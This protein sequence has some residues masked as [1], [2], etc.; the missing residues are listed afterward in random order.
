MPS[1]ERRSRAEA[2]R[3]EG[4]NDDPPY[5]D[6]VDQGL[7]APRDQYEYC[8]QCSELR[9][10][11]E[12]RDPDGSLPSTPPIYC[13]RCRQDKTPPLDRAPITPRQRRVLS[14]YI[15]QGARSSKEAAKIAGVSESYVR[16]LLA[17]RQ[18]PEVQRAFQRL[19]ESE[20]LDVFSLARYA[21]LLMGAVRPQWNRRS[22]EWDF[23]P[24]NAT[25]QT[26]WRH[27]TKL[28]DLIPMAHQDKTP[29]APQIVIIT[30]LDSKPGEAAGTFEIHTEKDVTPQ[31]HERKVIKGLALPGGDAPP[32]ETSP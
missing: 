17:G 19:L 11:I 1:A 14:A 29:T 13:Y 3:H 15:L 5:A 4:R 28:H 7:D 24:D 21:R 16:N 31:R 2:D 9:H 12:F 27:L 8:P 32:E 22:R 25:R 20:G 23:F 6:R 18:Y 10:H 26:V 30:N